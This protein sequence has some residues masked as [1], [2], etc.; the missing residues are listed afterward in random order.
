VRKEKK[1]IFDVFHSHFRLTSQLFHLLVPYYGLTAF[2]G[3]DNRKFRIELFASVKKRYVTEIAI[4]T[5]KVFVVKS[6]AST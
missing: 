5:T 1:N 3:Y 6:F 2:I 4:S